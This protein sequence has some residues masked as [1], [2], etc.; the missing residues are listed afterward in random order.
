MGPARRRRHGEQRGLDLN[1]DFTAAQQL[2]HATT[3]KRARFIE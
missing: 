2:I 1:Q 3:L